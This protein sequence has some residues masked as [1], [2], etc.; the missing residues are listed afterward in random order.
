MLSAVGTVHS[1][2]EIEA[3]Q[4]NPVMMDSNWFGTPRKRKLGE[5]SSWRGYMSCTG[6]SS[7]ATATGPSL[8]KRVRFVLRADSEPYMDP[9][10]LSRSSNSLMS[11]APRS[12]KRLR[13]I[14]ADGCS[15]EASGLTNDHAS[16]ADTT[17]HVSNLMST[18][19]H[20]S[21]IKRSPRKARRGSRE[22]IDLEAPEH[23]HS[24][25]R[26]SVNLFG[27]PVLIAAGAATSVPP[28]EWDEEAESEPLSSPRVSRGP[29]ASPGKARFGA[30]SPSRQYLRE[31]VDPARA[32]SED[33]DKLKVC[34]A[35]SCVE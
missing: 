10:D 9:E 31:D 22:V 13:Q 33:I 16:T 25:L 6:A 34:H 5:T 29:N 21:E 11:L 12:P 2:S 27:A 32:L 26:A 35:L 14:S 30:L 4:R 28:T 19:E 24:T 1:V 7:A 17:G 3:L 23:G 20:S 18:R 8:P 15:V